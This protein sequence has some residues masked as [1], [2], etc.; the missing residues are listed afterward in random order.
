MLYWRTYFFKNNQKFVTFFVKWFTVFSCSVCIN[1]REKN[2][3]FLVDRNRPYVK[4]ARMRENTGQNTGQNMLQNTGHAFWYILRSEAGMCFSFNNLK[5]DLLVSL[6]VMKICNSSYCCFFTFYTL[7]DFLIFLEK[8][9]RSYSFFS[10]F[11]R[12]VIFSYSRIEVLQFY[13]S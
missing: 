6:M 7:I 4:F 1:C 2:S 11:L 9:E 13:S 5:L 8:H 3:H 12:F 10:I